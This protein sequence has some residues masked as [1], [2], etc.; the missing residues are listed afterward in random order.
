MLNWQAWDVVERIPRFKVFEAW[1]FS[2]SWTLH[3][4]VHHLQKL[5]FYFLQTFRDLFQIF[6]TRILKTLSF[7]ENRRKQI[8]NTKPPTRSY[9]FQSWNARSS[10]PQPFQTYKINPIFSSPG[11][12]HDPKALAES[13]W[14]INSPLVFS[15]S[16]VEALEVMLYYPKELFP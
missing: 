11:D 2:F 5:L 3:L 13:R 9:L 10:R 15:N 16:T 14:D 1:S 7:A 8:K 6:M 12:I 4:A